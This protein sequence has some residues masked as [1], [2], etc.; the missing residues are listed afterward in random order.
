M[1]ERPFP[2]PL[3]GPSG[4]LL[5]KTL[6]AAGISRD[7]CYIINV[8][9]VRAPGDKFANH[10]PVDLAWGKDRLRAE[11]SSLSN[12]KVL[13]PL[14]ANPL[15]AILGGKPP[16]AQRGESRREGFITA[17]RGSV[18]GGTSRFPLEPEDYLTRLDIHP[19]VGVP[20]I[21]PTFHP[22]AV[23]RQFNWHPWSLL[24]FQ[25]VAEIARN[26]LPAKVYR[27]WYRNDVK[28]LERLAEEDIDVIAIDTELDPW[29]VGIATED[30]VHVFEWDEGFRPALTKIVTNPKIV[31]I[32]HRWLHDYAFFR[33]CL[34]ITVQGPLFDILGGAQ[35]LNYALQK[36]LSPHISTR[37]TYWPYHKWLTN[38]D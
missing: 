13:V 32:C 24:D 8:V 5:N 9:P 3:V 22:A 25:R 31:K 10:S 21:I 2:K 6:T 12:A 27:K 30:E 26:G 20:Y 36:E 14:G 15:E 34:N 35:N 4:R 1:A 7:E 17:W 29:I 28:A 19:I 37:F 11:L 18:I 38:V 33:K 23:L 16:V